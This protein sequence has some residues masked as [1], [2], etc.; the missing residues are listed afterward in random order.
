MK[1]YNEY[2]RVLFSVVEKEDL[3]SWTRSIEFMIHQGT[4]LSLS[5]GSITSAVDTLVRSIAK[6]FVSY[7]DYKSMGITTP[8]LIASSDLPE[9]KIILIPAFKGMLEEYVQIVD[10]FA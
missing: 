6:G 8:H 2:G 5:E 3:Y 1:H 9:G 10:M 4:V 7:E